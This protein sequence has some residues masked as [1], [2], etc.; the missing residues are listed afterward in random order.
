VDNDL[1]TISPA[2]YE[3][4]EPLPAPKSA[5]NPLLLVHRCLR[6]KYPLVALVA[7]LI[8][9]PAAIMGYRALPPRY[10]SVGIVRVAPTLPTTISGNEKIPEA[11]MLPRYEAFV[12]AQAAYLQSRRVLDRAIEDKDLRAAGWPQGPAGVAQLDK[13]LKVTVPVRS[14]LIM[15]SVS[16]PSPLAAQ[17]GLNAVLDAYQEIYGEQSGLAVSSRQRNLEERLRDLQRELTAYQNSVL[18]MGREYGTDDLDLLHRAKLDEKVQAEKALSEL[19]LA[20][21]QKQAHE[22]ATGGAP[23]TPESLNRLAESD[24]V[25]QKL[26]GDLA[27]LES[28]Q[29]TKSERFG[30]EH[31]DMKELARQIKSKQAEIAARERFA[32]ETLAPDPDG[33]ERTPGSRPLSLTEMTALRD[34]YRQRVEALNSDALRI[35]QSKLTIN[36]LKDQIRDKKAQIEETSHNLEAIKAEEANIKGGRVSIPARGDLPIKPAADRRIPL[37]IVGAASGPGISIVLFTLLGLVNRRYR[38]IDELEG[39]HASAPLLGT[40]PN[41]KSGDA[42]RDELAALSI[43]HLRNMLQIQASPGDG[44]GTAFAITSSSAGDGKTSLSL[45]LGMSFA[46]AGHRTLLLDGDLVGRGLTRQ[47]GM[48]DVSGLSE[49]VVLPT[50][51]GEV[52]ETSI[53]NLWAIPAGLNSGFEPEHLSQADLRRLLTQL[54][55]RYDIILVDTG[56]LLGSLEANLLA[57]LCNKVVLTVSRG[58]S[59]AL[60]QASVKRLARLGAE[61]AGL[62]FNRANITDLER[63]VSHTSVGLQSVRSVRAAQQDGHKK[64]LAGAGALA[65]AVGASSLP[66]EDAPPQEHAAP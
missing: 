20:I 31:R 53:R 42:Q 14:E 66:A 33:T 41:L 5:D 32:R 50:L 61:C 43:H 2:P 16:D 57:T 52:H 10:E 37:A 63:S 40:L 25:L 3:G 47:L 45:A 34:Q 23:P 44:R 48:S 55:A 36:N 60:V 1:A 65:R 19:E 15:V 17:K 30:P 7:V 22:N 26:L 9:V 13:A 4:P 59:A 8:A 11:A 27:A 38:Y 29:A 64:R 24:K 56:P 18:N 46:L 12:A 6:G 35:G 28:Q 51:N 49:A 21:S 39:P 54:R 58:Q 62:V